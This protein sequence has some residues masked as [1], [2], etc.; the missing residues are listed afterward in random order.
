[1]FCSF[2]KRSDKELDGVR[3]SEV[4]EGGRER[5]TEIT[6]EDPAEL[7]QV[8][9][10]EGGSDHHPCGVLP[11]S[12]VVRGGW[13]RVQVDGTSSSQPDSVSLQY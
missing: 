2:S 13:V 1:M 8:G 12:H 7:S 3:H 9:G 10:G 6:L 5:A 4:E 11:G